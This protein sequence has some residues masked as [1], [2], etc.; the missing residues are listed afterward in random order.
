MS[1]LKSGSLFE[2]AVRI[3]LRRNVSI[4]EVLAA[5]IEHRKDDQTTSKT[6][7]GKS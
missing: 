7:N 4:S 3:A 1:K 5:L 2:E 6:Q